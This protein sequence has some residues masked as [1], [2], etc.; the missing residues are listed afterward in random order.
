MKKITFMNTAMIKV[1]PMYRGTRKL[2]QP[3][4]IMY[5]INTLDHEQYRC[6]FIEM[7][8]ENLL[9]EDI[10][11][12][13][14]FI[15]STTTS[16]LQWNNYF[17]SLRNIDQVLNLLQQKRRDKNYKLIIFGP[18]CINHYK[19]FTDRGVDIVIVGEPE[20]VLS[21]VV[22]KSLNNESLNDFENVV[23]KE[24]L[25]QGFIPRTLQVDMRN[26]P[27]P[28]WEICGS[29]EYSAHNSPKVFQ[30]GFLYETSRGCPFQCSY[31]NTETHR[32][33]Y[34]TKPVEQ[35]KHDLER[36]VYEHGAEYV[37]FIDESFGYDD[38][39]VDRLLPILKEI[40]VEW[41]CQGNI[42]FT[43]P[44]KLLKM[45]EA[46]CISMEF[47]LETFNNEILKSVRKS[48]DLTR[49]R[50]LIDA[51]LNA[52][53]SPL[54]FLLIGL[55]GETLD[56]LEKTVDF[57]GTLKPGFRFSTGIPT[58]YPNTHYYRQGIEQG[59]IKPG[60][61]DESLY[62]LSGTINNNLVW[63]RNQMN[64]FLNDYGPNIWGTPQN[65][66]RFSVDVFKMFK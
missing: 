21:E 18:H 46:G 4:D 26:I 65:I 66:K 27:S 37:Y 16:Y 10:S 28:N 31:C 47:G 32:R 3:L 33:L 53:I 19:Y 35:I 54:L 38:E 30:K 48:N 39:W 7:A 22:Y 44:E 25:L 20:S 17:L 49:V 57:L 14:V 11:N 55:P 12:E 60:Q 23:T 42:K 13:D 41:G 50:E 58:P 56:S 34:R 2:L 29:H 52:G 24:K 6:R 45:A 5:A 43:T 59:I 61:N 63:D 51:A 62:L 9:D 1:D 8:L 64:I 40:P 15:V 36:M